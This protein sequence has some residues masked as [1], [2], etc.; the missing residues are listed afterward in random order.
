[1]VYQLC[2]Y[3]VLISFFKFKVVESSKPE[4]EHSEVMKYVAKAAQQANDNSKI[5][6]IIS[7]SCFY[8]E[9]NSKNIIL[10]MMYTVCLYPRLL[11]NNNRKATL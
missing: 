5:T 7:S 9:V 11:L 2:A 6:C 4:T 8:M 10:C 1:M 3:I